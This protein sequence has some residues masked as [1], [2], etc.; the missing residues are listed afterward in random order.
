M[1]VN[2]FVKSARRLFDELVA[3]SSSNSSSKA[4]I[5]VG[6][7]SADPDSIASSI[8]MAY[9][10][11]TNN[12]DTNAAPCS[13]LPIINSSHATLRSKREC[14]HLFNML[15]IDVGDLVLLA[16]VRRLT[17]SR[18]GQVVLVDHNELDED[19]RSLDFARLVTGLVDHHVDKG[20]FA[21]AS[22]RLVDTTAGSNATLI[23]SRFHDDG[24]QLN[25]SF[26]RLLIVPI[27]FDTNNLTFRASQRDKDMLIYLRQ[28]TDLD[29][30]RAYEQLDELKFAVSV[31]EET[32]V[33]LAKDY[34]QY[35]D[36][37]TRQPWG[38]SSVNFCI[39]EWLAA[40]D[41]TRRHRLD[42]VGEFMADKR[43]FVFAMLSCYKVD[44]GSFRRDLAVFVAGSA[45]D[46]LTRVF[47]DFKDDRLQAIRKQLVADKSPIGYALYHVADVS[48]T[49]KYWQPALEKFL[50]SQS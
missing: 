24:H 21:D 32:S 38:M 12:T 44:G 11:S 37:R 1:K 35:E 45:E 13:F 30:A 5:V 23:A 31:D 41:A 26:A 42:E 49:R 46:L 8:A 28:F 10:L 7:Q 4:N 6:N 27:L 50:A 47:D 22:P 2:D 16:D 20:L 18:I 9:Q 3:S 33:L 25:D 15:S 34:K 19:E 48:L 36:V 39:G 17:A 29:V 14:M 43:L 40:S